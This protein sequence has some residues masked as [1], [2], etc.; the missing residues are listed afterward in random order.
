MNV[1]EAES[2]EAAPPSAGDYV[3]CNVWVRAAYTSDVGAG[4]STVASHGA[5]LAPTQLRRLGDGLT[6]QTLGHGSLK[7]TVTPAAPISAYR[8]ESVG[9]GISLL[10]SLTSLDVGKLR[11]LQSAGGVALTVDAANETDVV[12]GLAPTLTS[13][14]KITSPLQPFDA[15]NSRAQAEGHRA[16]CDLC[17]ARWW[18]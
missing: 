8:L 15:G 18:P 16:D 10:S 14:R 13:V 6:F 12:I 9:K 4:T 7:L 2:D 3:N 1:Y 5:G 17:A 11:G